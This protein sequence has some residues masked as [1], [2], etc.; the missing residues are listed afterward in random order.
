MLKS[1]RGTV[2]IEVTGNNV[3]DF[4]NA[5]RDE[6]IVCTSQRCENGVFYGDV[7]GGDIKKAETIA[8]DRG[9]RLVI[10][11]KKGLRFRLLAYRYRLGLMIGL[12]GALCLVFYF[13]NTVI[14]ID[15]SGNSAVT[16]KQILTALSEM[17][18]Q[19]GAFIP[20]IN[21]Q[22]CEQQLRLS[23]PQLSWVG[24]RH[25]GSRIAVDIEEAV[26]KP[27]MVNDDIPCNIVAARDAQ[28]TQIRVYDGQRVKQLMDGVKKGDPIISGIIDDGKGHIL[29]KHAKGQVRGIYYD[30][31]V[32]SQS[33]RENR[34]EYTGI[35][36]RRRYFNFFG[37]RIPLYIGGEEYSSYDYSERE[38]PFSIFGIELPLGIVHT[39]YKPFEYK[40]VSF[41]QQEAEKIVCEKTAMYEKNFLSDRYTVILKRKIRRVVLG[42]RIEYHVE[43]KVEGDIAMD[44]EIYIGR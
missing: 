30:R 29:K 25:V 40:E 39:E 38:N 42:D 14:T 3:Y 35:S 11:K 31:Q 23:I 37:L 22:R 44:S 28:I 2:S 34:Q 15:V 32:F 19:K 5:L 18:V 1:I 17:G 41:T 24:I 8:A 10:L 43:Y 7:Y 9:F 26:Q 4:I 6:H 16:E 12:L 21:F 33:F 20:E 13:S 27:R 36:D